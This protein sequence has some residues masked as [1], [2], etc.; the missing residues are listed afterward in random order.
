M[1][2]VGATSLFICWPFMIEGIIIGLISGGISL[3]LTVLVEYFEGDAMTSLLEMFGSQAIDFG[4]YMPLLTDEMIPSGDAFPLSIYV[5]LIL[6]IGLYL[7]FSLLPFPVGA[8]PYH[9]ALILS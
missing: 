4:A 3:G 9:A 5:A 1:K 6:G 8:T 7:K 2:S